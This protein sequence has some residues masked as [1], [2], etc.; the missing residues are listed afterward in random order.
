MRTFTE[1]ELA[2]LITCPKQVVDAQRSSA[3]KRLS[4]TKE[5]FKGQLARIQTDIDSQANGDDPERVLL[6]V[7]RAST[8]K[9]LSG[10]STFEQVAGGGVRDPEV[11]GDPAA[12]RRSSGTTYAVLGLLLGL[13]LGCA[14]VVVRR[15]LSAAVFSEADLKRYGS[16]VPVLAD[17]S[18]ADEAT[19][20]VFAALASA[21]GQAPAPGRVPGVLF[22]GVGANTVPKHLPSGVLEALPALGLTGSTISPSRMT[23]RACSRRTSVDSR[24]RCSMR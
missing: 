21:C 10:L 24:S 22:A 11:V 3:E 17:I 12:I 5:L 13:V 19:K 14:F 7:D 15:F 9:V 4:A 23:G 16:T 1:D 18:G 20:G 6:L 2:A 8:I